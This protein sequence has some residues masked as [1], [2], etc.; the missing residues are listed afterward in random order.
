MAE[1]VKSK[2]YEQLK[3]KFDAE[4]ITKETLQ[5]WVRLNAKKATKGITKEEYAEITGEEFPEDEEG[6]G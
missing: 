5:G 2:M 3:A 6:E 4:Y 1:T